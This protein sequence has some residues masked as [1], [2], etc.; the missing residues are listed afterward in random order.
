MQLKGLNYYIPIDAGCS[1]LRYIVDLETSILDMD[2]AFYLVRNII[3]LLTRKEIL[4]RRHFDRNCLVLLV[5]SCIALWDD[6][7]FLTEV[8]RNEFCETK[9]RVFC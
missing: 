1:F 7:N 2:R 3:P 9:F 4:R 8:S 5:R 6:L